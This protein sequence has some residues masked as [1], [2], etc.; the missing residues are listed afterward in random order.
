MSAPKRR[1]QLSIFLSNRPG[2]LEEVCA[3]LARA[4]VNLLAMTVSDTVDACIVRL[5]PD[6]PERAAHLLEAGGLLVLET[7][8]LVVDLPHRAGALRD[9]SA[10]LAKAGVNIE[11]LYATVAPGA[12]KASVILRPN[13]LEKA[14]R[15]LGGRR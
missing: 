11:Y 15:I 8:V 1:V 6:D 14:E 2:V 10:K 3:T 7:D 5:V 4:D 9:L 13:H 12:K